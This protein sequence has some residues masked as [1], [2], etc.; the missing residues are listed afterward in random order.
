MIYE[1]RG[2]FRPPGFGA[3][4]D[5]AQHA[6]GLLRGEKELAFRQL[7]KLFIP[8][9]SHHGPF[10]GVASRAKQQVSHLVG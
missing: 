9:P 2:S 5:V 7:V 6:G 4:A 1:I 8:P 3:L 10:R